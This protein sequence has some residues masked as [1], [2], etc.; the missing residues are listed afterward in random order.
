MLANGMEVAVHSVPRI[1]ARDLAAVLPGVPL[2]HLLIVTACQ[3]AR[4]DLVNVGAD[5]AAE[6]DAL[7][8]RV[9]VHGA[10]RGAGFNTRAP[11]TY[12]RHPTRA[13]PRAVYGVGRWR[14]GSSGG[15]RAARPCM[16]GLR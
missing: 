5:V 16:G 10:S 7:L 15:T 1:L 12:H 14:Q 6:K 8:E 4:L 11:H 9:R 3:R 2:E 13:T